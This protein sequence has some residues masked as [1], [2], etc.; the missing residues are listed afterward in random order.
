MQPNPIQP[1]TDVTWLRD[2]VLLSEQVRK[3][4]DELDEPIR[5]ALNA[6]Y[7]QSARDALEHRMGVDPIH[8]PHDG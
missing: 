8:G 5:E 4:V 1:H 2:L 6:A 3:R 7:L